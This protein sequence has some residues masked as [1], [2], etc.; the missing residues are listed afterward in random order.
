MTSVSTPGPLNPGN[1]VS[2]ALRMYRDRF[3][4]YF[5][6]SLI[7]VLWVAVPVIGFVVVAAVIAGAVG[8]SVGL[9]GLLALVAIVLLVYCMAKYNLYAG[10]IARLAFRELINEPETAAEARRQLQ[11][12]LWSFL[13]LGFL[14]LV[15][16]LA[17]YL[18]LG[19]GVGII[20]GVAGTVVG[21]L[22][23]GIFGEGGAIIGGVLTFLIVGLG[24]LFGMLWVVSRVFIADVPLSTEARIGASD[25]IGRSWQLTKRSVLRIQF[26]VVAAY[27][28]TLPAVIVTLIPQLL[29]ARLEPGS[30]AYNVGTLALL[31]VSFAINIA[32]MPF[33][34]VV[35][36]VLYYDLR[37]R[38]EGLDLSM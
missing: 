1:V 13:W 20:G 26:V 22:L 8:P 23:S 35:K 3:K 17:A 24:V 36:G 11:P 29:I 12:K 10:A 25:S 18:V 2:A 19:I 28:V 5:G 14:L 21:A 31:I 34:Q 9:F 32:V 38:R 37:S 30:T 4:T 7:A 33:W 16:F 27:L 6:L 15:I